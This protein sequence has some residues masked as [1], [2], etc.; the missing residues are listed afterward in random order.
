MGYDTGEIK[1][2]KFISDKYA[3]GFWIQ[4]LFV[5]KYWVDD[6][7]VNFEMTDAAIEKSVDVS[8]KLISD[9]SIDSIIDFGKFILAKK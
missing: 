6:K 3:H 8:F 5:L 1:E 9:T 4:A 2:R 7:S